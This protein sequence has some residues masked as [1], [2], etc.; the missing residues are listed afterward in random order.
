MVTVNFR[1]LGTGY[2]P[3]W[4]WFATLPLLGVLALALGGWMQRL[5][6]AASK[7]FSAASWTPSELAPDS[8]SIHRVPGQL[9]L[10]QLPLRFE[11]NQGQTDPRV[12]FLARGAGYGVFLTPDK[13]VLTLGSGSK[14]SSIVRMQLA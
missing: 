7:Q 1:A 13:A 6:V 3:V 9:A 2:R 5:P 4:L 12:K 14:N 11:P 8:K 10:G